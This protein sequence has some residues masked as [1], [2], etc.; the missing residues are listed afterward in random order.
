MYVHGLRISSQKQQPTCS[1]LSRRTGKT[2]VA[3]VNVR[4]F[5]FWTDIYIMA[6]L[7]LHI[8]SPLMLHLTKLTL[9]HSEESTRY[10][11]SFQWYPAWIRIHQSVAFRSTQTYV[12]ARWLSR[13]KKF[14]NNLVDDHWAY[15]RWGRLTAHRNLT[16]PHHFS[17][18]VQYHYSAAMSAD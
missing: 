4:G 16:D 12:V 17:T 2:N 15:D 18:L 10:W 3:W 13:R 7:H 14:W 11:Y 1:S 6:V 5:N 9:L 8:C